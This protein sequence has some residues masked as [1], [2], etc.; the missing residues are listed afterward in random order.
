MGASAIVAGKQVCLGNAEWIA[1]QGILIDPDIKERVESLAKDGKTIVY[2]AREI[3]LI[4]LIA[5]QDILRP[6]A[7]ETVTTLQKMGLEVV[8]LSGDR[9]IIT[10]AIASELGISQYFAEIKPN[11]KAEII[12]TLQKDN[13]RIVAQIGDGI[14]DAPALA[15]ADIGI[16]LH[17]STDVARETAGIILMQERLTD[18]VKSIQ[19]SKATFNKIRQ[20][21][22]WALGYNTIAIPVAAGVLLPSFGILL[23]PVVAAALMA[24]SSTIV[25]TNSLLLRREFR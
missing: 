1:K 20:N 4:G 7:I 16:S 9:E 3:E 14:N 13:K 12:K 25:V 21:L 23:S 15:Q 2:I 6:D 10:K 22:I 19:L 18:V 8:L 11:G 24:S 17:H 5:L